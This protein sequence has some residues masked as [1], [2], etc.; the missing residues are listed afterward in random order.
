MRWSWGTAPSLHS[1]ALKPLIVFSFCKGCGF[2]DVCNA[3]RGS[4]R[5]HSGSLWRSGWG[6]WT[7]VG[8]TDVANAAA[9]TTTCIIVILLLCFCKTKTDVKQRRSDKCCCYFKNFLL[10]VFKSHARNYTTLLLFFSNVCSE[11]GKSTE[12]ARIYLEHAK[13]LEKV[14]PKV[15]GIERH[16]LYSK[17]SSCLQFVSVCVRLWRPASLEFADYLRAHRMTLFWNI[18]RS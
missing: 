10:L 15:S 14:A 3:Y 6:K 9:A 13:F 5:C 8:G 18:T 17:F 1:I 12:Q 11:L 7:V 2:Q 4:P 16:W